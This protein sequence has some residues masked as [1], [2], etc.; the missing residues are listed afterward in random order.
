MSTFTKSQN[1]G[2]DTTLPTEEST[3]AYA[4]PS[5]A[6]QSQVPTAEASPHVPNPQ[7]H[8]FIG[9][10]P[11]Q[12]RPPY[13]GQESTYID[14]RP[15]PM[16]EVKSFSPSKGSEG[17]K[18]CVGISAIYEL[19]AVSFPLMFGSRRC[20]TVLTKTIQRGRLHQYALTADVPSFS[21]TE[22]PQP[23][24]T[25]LMHMEGED[26]QQLGVATVGEF[27]YINGAVDTA[28]P[29][30]TTK[31]PRKRKVSAESLEAMR[32]PQKRQASQ[33]LRPKSSD[34]YPQYNYQPSSQVPPYS[35]YLQSPSNQNHYQYAS[36]YDRSE[37]QNCYPQQSSPGQFSQT[38]QFTTTSGVPQPTIKAPS[39]ASWSPQTY[40]AVGPQA[41]RS[42][43]VTA[44]PHPARP[45]ATPQAVSSP[46]TAANPPLIRTSTLQ[47]APSPASTPAGAAKV[48][49][50]FNPYAMYPH[51]AVLKINGDLDGLAEGWSH[52]E[53]E[54]KRRI[55]QF[56]RHQNGSAIHTNFSPVASNERP[57]NSI[58][59]SCIWWE[60]KKECF[61]TSVDTIYLLESLV[62]VRFT[63]EEK[64]RIRRNLE[65][66]RPL[67]VS[68][69]KAESEDFFKLI[70][71]FPN[72]KP[73]NIEKDVK[74]FPW[75]ILAHAL[76]KIIGKY[77]ASY[78][79]TAG[80]L[81]TPVNSSGYGNG[82]PGGANTSEA[83]S[84]NTDRHITASPRSATSSTTSSVYPIGITT[85]AL[86]PSIK[87]QVGPQPRGGAPPEL[88][89]AVPAVGPASAA[90]QNSN[91]PNTWP[92]PH[93]HHPA[94]SQDG[95][96][97]GRVAWDFTSFIDDASPASATPGGSQVIQYQRGIGIPDHRESNM[98]HA[99]KSQQISGA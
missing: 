83:G 10:S 54:A 4:P 42:P 56:W 53:W 51:K 98:V 58:C 25:V 14:M 99:P 15:R 30:A 64:N 5:F 24:V 86:S 39:P 72:P 87:Q 12:G 32:S 49:Q 92:Q 34:E 61:V 29:G 21:E 2:F 7:A 20:D 66:F 26:G 77:S 71:S 6:P 17:T 45:A 23:Q 31:N 36:G 44:S 96:A 65:G 90:S 41:S 35:P 88:R 48:G 85:T 50:P 82:T 75:K 97:G 8:P 69:A 63:V 28:Y 33:Q 13:D 40:Q 59:I 55:V 78:S 76:K 80:A 46:S 52:E 18:I 67:T 57:P 9:G 73:R 70:M 43:G 74:V 95:S 68:K 79:S 27:T 22:W 37:P 91:A 62:A 94:Q 38:Y 1:A 89:V 60:E 47:Q 93:M 16:P 19:A 81:L 11:Y 3:Y 84:S